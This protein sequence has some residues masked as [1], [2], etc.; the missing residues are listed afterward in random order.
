MGNSS[1]GSMDDAKQVNDCSFVTEAVPLYIMNNVPVGIFRFGSAMLYLFFSFLII[2]WIKKQ[3][4]N[5]K[6]NLYQNTD[7]DNDVQ[8][9]ILSLMNTPFINNGYIFD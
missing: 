9:G 2:Y 5:A 4:R 7:D 6:D 8:S 3:E 1:S